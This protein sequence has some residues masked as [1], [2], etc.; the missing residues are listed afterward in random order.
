MFHSRR[1]GSV[2]PYISRPT[3]SYL[4]TLIAPWR[5]YSLRSS[6]CFRYRQSLGED[7]DIMTG[8]AIIA[9]FSKPPVD[10]QHWLH[11]Q[12]HP[13]RGPM[14]IPVHRQFHSGSPKPSPILTRSL[15]SPRSTKGSVSALRRLFRCEGSLPFPFPSPNLLQRSLAGILYRICQ[16]LGA[17]IQ[18]TLNTHQPLTNQLA[19]VWRASEVPSLWCGATTS[20]GQWPISNDEELLVENIDW[21]LGRLHK[22]Q[23][24]VRTGD[25]QCC[26]CLF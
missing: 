1:R 22:W 9:D 3:V 13:Q 25:L 6:W 26:S 20:E 11:H 10:S 19:L 8:D 14:D 24:L 2:S 17:E 15:N 5:R 21:Q 16:D 18:A 23:L 4:F 12:Q 7:V